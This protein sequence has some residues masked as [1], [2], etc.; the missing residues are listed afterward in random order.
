MVEPPGTLMD[1]AI[2]APALARYR[3]AKSVVLP[4]LPGPRFHASSIAP[5]NASGPL[6]RRG[7]IESST[8]LHTRAKP[9]FRRA[10][11]EPLLGV[12]PD[13]IT[14]RATSRIWLPGHPTPTGQADGF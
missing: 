7:P 8:P 6:G 13:C 5:C 10:S 14:M 11:A 2:R 1:R 4:S 9:L 12:C 3:S